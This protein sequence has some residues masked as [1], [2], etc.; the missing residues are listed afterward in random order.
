M[1]FYLGTH[2]LSWL[3]R[4][5]VPLFVSAVRFKRRTYPRAVCRFGLDSGG[6]SVLRKAGR[7]TLTDSEHADDVRRIVERVGMPDFAAPR[8]MMCEPFMLEKTGLT[9]RE[10]QEMTIASVLELRRRAPEVPWLP[11]LQGW[12]VGEYLDH[13][14]QYARAGVNL[15][16]E[17]VVGVGSVCR[18]QGTSDGERIIRAIAARGIRVHAFGVKV[19]GLARYGEVVASADSMAWSFAARRRRIRMPGC[20]HPCCNNCM[21]WAM[22]WR[23]GVLGEHLQLALPLT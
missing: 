3:T 18:R 22:E 4:S 8:D 14:E 6:F 13:V 11:V 21:R 10:H 7:W 5:R 15:L 1:R 20:D 12:T 16:T 2:Q 19:D 23:R 17:P 9:V